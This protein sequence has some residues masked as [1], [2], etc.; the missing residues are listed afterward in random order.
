MRPRLA[1]AGSL[2][3]ALILVV[4]GP[5]GANPTG[6]DERRAHVSPDKDFTPTVAASARL[7]RYFVVMKAPSAVDRLLQARRTHRLFSGQSETAARDAA[8]ASQSQAIA[9]ARARGGTIV[10]RFGTLV[11][12][13]SA[14][15]TPSVARALARRPDVAFVQPVS[16]M[17]LENSTSVPFI[18]AP[19]VWSHFGARGQS[20]T[21]ALVDTG[22]D[23]TH[24]DFGGPGTVAAYENNDPNFVEP[25]TFPTAKVIG[26]YDFV[27]SNYD[28]LDDD[29]SNDIPRPD[30]DPLDRDGHGTHTGGTCCGIGVPGK[31]G[32][33]L[34]RT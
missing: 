26:G 34:P 8:L 14:H 22:I 11:N 23:Y 5:S 21:L 3:L 7:S 30:A 24:K 1:L 31:V 32:P 29:T 9:A 2:A 12:A 6:R 25:G 4:V 10:F 20:M 16:I 18:G 15:L 33:A 27:G 13:F 19:K 28:V 17:R